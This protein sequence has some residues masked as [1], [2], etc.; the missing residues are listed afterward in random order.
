MTNPPP[1]SDSEDIPDEELGGVVR[2][3]ASGTSS[4]AEMQ[5]VRDTIKN[6]SARRN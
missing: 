2:R 6:E 1:P 4:N 3:L 5:R